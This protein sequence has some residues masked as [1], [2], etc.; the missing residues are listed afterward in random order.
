MSHQTHKYEIR[1]EGLSASEAGIKAA[2][3]RRELL[4]VSP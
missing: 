3:L 1:F 2:K 4:G